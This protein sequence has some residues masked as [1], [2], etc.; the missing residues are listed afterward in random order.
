VINEFLPHPHSDWNDDG[1][2]TVADEFI[3]IINLST[4][5]VTLNNWKLD[6]G[7]N[8][9]AYGLPNVTLLSQQIQVFFHSET[10]LPL[11]DGGGTVRLLR[12]D[13]RT[14][15]IYNYSPVEAMEQTW[16]R[17]SDRNSGNLAL[18]CRPSPGKPNIPFDPLFSTPG[19]DPVT[20]AITNCG[21]A[22]TIPLAVTS[23]E[24]GGFGVG[25]WNAA[26][27]NQFWLPE[28]GKWNVFVE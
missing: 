7:A 14:A 23:A 13:G 21:L 9:S 27:E 2:A 19:S 12:S 11:S 8:T 15:D 25:I 26:P 10:G 20:N 5:P 4:S 28:H 1:V 24:C 17:L 16:C 6:N 22:D 18:A 3:E